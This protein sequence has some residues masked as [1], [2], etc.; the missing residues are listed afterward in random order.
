MEDQNQNTIVESEL[1]GTIPSE[2]QGYSPNNPPWGFWAAILLWVVSVILIVA[3]QTLFII[4][5]VVSQNVSFSD[6]EALTKFVTGDPMAIFISIA[7]VIPAHILTLVLGW[8]IVTNFRKYSFKKMLGWDWGGYNWWQVALGTIGLVIAVFLVAVIT[9]LIFGEKENDFDKILKSSRYV[10]LLV[11]FVATFSAPITEEVVYRGVMYS[12]FQ[13]TFSRFK[14]FQNIS[15]PITVILVT[16]IFA[17]VHYVQYWGDPAT[18]I[19][20]T[21]LSLVI[22]L[23]RVKTDSLLPCIFFH[24][25]INGIQSVVLVLQPYLPESMNPAKTEA[26]LFLFK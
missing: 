5:Y 19:T 4:P 14:A 20:I 9:T 21:F 18:I 22:T 6:P 25:V 16:L 13:R 17:G 15:I 11:A 12:A 7:S 24:F 3:I 2:L 1:S 8:F 26:F 10:V 23:I